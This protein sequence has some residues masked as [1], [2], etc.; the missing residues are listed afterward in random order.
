M[1][2]GAHAAVLGELEQLAVAEVARPALQG[3]LRWARGEA[4]YMNRAL[5]VPK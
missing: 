2:S 1:R 4:P 3:V 5:N